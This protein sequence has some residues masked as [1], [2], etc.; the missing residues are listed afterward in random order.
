MGDKTQLF[1]IG[2]SAKH[3]TRDVLLGIGIA[4]VLLNA[5]GVFMGSVLAK[6]FP[7]EYVSLAAGFFFLVFALLTLGKDEKN[8]IANRSS[9]L[10]IAVAFFLAELGDKTQLS[11]IAFSAS[12][13]NEIWSVFIGAT[14]GMLIADGV[15]ILIAKIMGKQIPEK[16]M[17]AAA[18]LIFTFY[19]F[20]TIFDH[21]YLFLPGKSVPLTLTIAILYA[22]FSFI[23]LKGRKREC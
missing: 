15:G 2:L 10:G 17:K 13:P 9:V 11:A 22:F 18:Y 16:F 20:K 1:V 12:N 21:F 5:M 23:L 3:K 19:G 6:M 14:C 7:F 4:T 8:K